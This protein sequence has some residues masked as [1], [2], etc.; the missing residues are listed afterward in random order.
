ME[1]INL[2]ITTLD[3]NPSI[4]TEEMLELII[5]LMEKY[6]TSKQLDHLIDKL[7]KLEY[8]TLN[9]DEICKFVNGLVGLDSNNEDER[10]K[11]KS[12][13]P[14]KYS[15]EFSQLLELGPDDVLSVSSACSYSNGSSKWSEWVITFGKVNPGGYISP[16]ARVTVH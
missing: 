6:N 16:G 12:T 10:F 15:Y 1:T 8:S 7:V 2:L 3:S 5:I 4:S 9:K 11:F 13:N 14:G